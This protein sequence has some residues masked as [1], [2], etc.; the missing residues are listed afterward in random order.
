MRPESPCFFG[1]D[2]SLN[3]CAVSLPH[4]ISVEEGEQGVSPSERP[5]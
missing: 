2:V 4:I 1:T 5:S 3:T